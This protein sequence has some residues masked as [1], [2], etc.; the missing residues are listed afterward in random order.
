MKP[1]HSSVG[2]QWFRSWLVRI[3]IE[4][5]THVAMTSQCGRT[6]D[7][8][9]LARMD[10]GV[11]T[12]EA[13]TPQFRNSIVDKGLVDKGLVIYKGV[14]PQWGE[15]V[16]QVLVARVDNKQPCVTVITILS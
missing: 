11:V 15:L 2:G 7:Q 9:L 5:V 4:V 12:Y 3:D 8:V 10:I 1:S 6:V 16:V 13:L 14:I